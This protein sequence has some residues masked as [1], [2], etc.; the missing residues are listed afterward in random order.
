MTDAH[1]S[2]RPEEARERN[3]R[4]QRIDQFQADSSFDSKAL[5]SNE[6]GGAPATAAEDLLPSKDC[7]ETPP[8]RPA[9]VPA[10]GSGSLDRE[11]I[12]SA[13]FSLILSPI[14]GQPSRKEFNVRSVRLFVDGW[15]PYGMGLGL[16]NQARFLSGEGLYRI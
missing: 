9:F 13:A 7:F 11:R 14:D 4:Y 16:P 12:L 8:V 5:P 6:G 10:P 3:S 15:K 1:V 2:D